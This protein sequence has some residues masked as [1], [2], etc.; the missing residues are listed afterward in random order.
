M[1]FYRF[2]CTIAQ[3]T[4]VSLLQPSAD[5]VHVE[6]MVAGSP[7]GNTLL[8]RRQ[9]VVDLTLDA[10]VQDVAL[11]HCTRVLDEVPFPERYS[12]VWFYSLDWLSCCSKCCKLLT[13]FLCKGTHLSSLSFLTSWRNNQFHNSRLGYTCLSTVTQVGRENTT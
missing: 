2:Q 8:A 11:A 9:C 1:A 13:F 3:W 6:G 12:L 7:R 10:Q 5:T 4:N